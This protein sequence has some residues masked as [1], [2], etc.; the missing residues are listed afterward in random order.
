[1]DLLETIRART[2]K[3]ESAKLVDSRNRVVASFPF[4]GRLSLTNEFEIARGELAQVFYEASK[5][6]AE[7]VFGER[8]SKIE[9]MGDCAEVT[10]ASEDGN[11]RQYDVVVVAEGLASRTRALVLGED[12]RAPIKPL[13]IWVASFSFA[14]GENDDQWARVYHIPN[15]RALFIRPDGLGRVKSQCVYY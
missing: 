8:I 9:E 5:V 15:R 12:V 4:A 7:Y 11:K 14:Q 1:M 2:T 6:K 13:H 10:F 3:E